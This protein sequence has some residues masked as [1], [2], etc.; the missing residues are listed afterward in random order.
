VTGELGQKVQKMCVIYFWTAPSGN[1]KM[2]A[3]KPEINVSEQIDEIKTK[4]QRLKF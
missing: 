1:S 4:C 2:A 3:T